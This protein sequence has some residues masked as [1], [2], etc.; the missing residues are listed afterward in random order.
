MLEKHTVSAD[1]AVAAAT[2]LMQRRIL[3]PY[4]FQILHREFAIGIKTNCV[5]LSEAFHRLELPLDQT[6]QSESAIWEIAAET[7]GEAGA[8]LISR[9]DIDLIE[10]Y[11]IGPSC[12]ARMDSGSWFALTPPSLNG[13]GFAMVTGNERDQIHQ[14]SSYLRTVLRFLDDACGRSLPSLTLEVTA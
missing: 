13:V 4:S 6:C 12:A 2:D 10:I 8:S 1:K 3:L 14:L 5:L 7:R 9:P 11:R